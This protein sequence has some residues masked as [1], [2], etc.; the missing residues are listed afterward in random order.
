MNWFDFVIF[1]VIGL[2][3]VVSFFRGILREILSLVIWIL[4]FILSFKYSS[5]VSI[6]LQS[7]VHGQMISYVLAFVLIFLAVFLFGM[8]L[9]FFIKHVIDKVGF[10]PIDRV[11]GFCFGA[12]RG[13]I[14]VTVLLM[15]IAVSPMQKEAWY[16]SSKVAPY[17]KTAVTWLSNF[18]PDQV[19]QVSSWLGYP[20]QSEGMNHVRHHRRFIKSAR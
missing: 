7:F 19:Q 4:A 11:L 12:A 1:G 9:N 15:F 10:G 18:L 8:V 3:I 14:V 17:F 13:V 6:W 5:S 20:Q 16:A 2:S